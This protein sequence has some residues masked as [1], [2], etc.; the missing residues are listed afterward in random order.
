MGRLWYYSE[1]SFKK[2]EFMEGR[3][4]KL[5]FEV[6]SNLEFYVKF[7]WYLSAYGWDFSV[8]GKSR[9]DIL[10]SL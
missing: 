9:A 6:F 3:E 8:F 2:R 10:L 1:L 7:S 5:I 4:S